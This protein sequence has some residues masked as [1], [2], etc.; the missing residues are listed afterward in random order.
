[1]LGSVVEAE[2]AATVVHRFGQPRAVRV[3]ISASVLLQHEILEGEGWVAAVSVVW[4]EDRADADPVQAPID[5]V[6]AR[7]STD[8]A[9]ADHNVVV[10]CTDLTHAILIAEYPL[11]ARIVR[12]RA[13]VNQNPWHLLLLKRDSISVQDQ[14]ALSTWTSSAIFVAITA[15]VSSLVLKPL[16]EASIGLTSSSA[17]NVVL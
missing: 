4:A 8:A 9:N 17:S 2:T 12:M 5:A 15:M 13:L 1:M 10:E 7:L 11:N 16:R 6:A 14:A 3:E